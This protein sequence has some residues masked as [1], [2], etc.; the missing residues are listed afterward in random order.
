MKTQNIFI[1]IFTLLSPTLFAQTIV[2][3]G[4]ADLWLAGMPDGSTASF[5]DIAPDE[6]PI[7]VTGISI[8][9]GSAYTFSASGAVSRGDPLPFYGPLGEPNISDH[10]TGVENGI[11]DITAPICS[12]IGVFLGPDMPNLNPAPDALD[13]STPSSQDYLTLSP[14]L[15]QPFYIGD[16]LTSLGALHQVVAPLGATRLFIGTMDEYEWSNN[17]GSFNVSIQ[18]VPEP[19]ITSLVSIC[20]TGLWFFRKWPN[21]IR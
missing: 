6:S 17:E 13:F 3:P 19:G 7:L 15:Q 18:V 4:T 2:V 20:L 16:G 10:W 5:D 21:K 14:E 12:F 1:L 9:S 11:A 8:T